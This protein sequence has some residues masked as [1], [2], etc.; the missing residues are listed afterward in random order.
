M[1]FLKRTNCTSDDFIFL[2]PPENAIED[3]FAAYST[4]TDTQHR[5]LADFLL[6][7]TKARWMMTVKESSNILNLYQGK[8]LRM[9][10]VRR[11]KHYMIITNY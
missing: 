8:G 7:E 5:L 2:D 10:P 4:F 6:N 9:T 1:T 11:R 3:E